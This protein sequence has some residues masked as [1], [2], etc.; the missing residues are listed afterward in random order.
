MVKS[1]DSAE[2]PFFDKAGKK[3]PEDTG[4]NRE[5]PPLF[6]GLALRISSFMIS[7]PDLCRILENSVSA[8]HIQG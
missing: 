4:E 8:F 2:E 3:Q 1:F 5:A 7:S 6:L